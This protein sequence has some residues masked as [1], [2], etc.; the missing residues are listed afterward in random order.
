MPKQVNLK[1]N[2]TKTHKYINREISW[3]KFNLRVLSEAGNKNIPL[4]ERVRFLSIAA[5][6]LD[7]FFM[8]RVAGIFNQIKERVDVVST[9]GLNPEQQLDKIIDITKFLLKK[10]N[11]VW[12]NLKVNLNKEGIFF[13]RYNELNSSEKIRLGKYFREY[14]Y[15][16]LTP[17]IIDPAH[18]FPF[19]PNQ[20]LFVVMS[21]NKKKKNKNKKRF[22]LILIPKKIERFINISNKEGIKKYIALNTSSVATQIFCFLITK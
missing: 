13:V 17:L 2:L 12:A 14:I 4:L 15:P 21:L 1:E 20:G 3:L 11:D 19:I 7:E 9:D 22:S 18:P 8:V 10:S 16:V 5:N 6:N